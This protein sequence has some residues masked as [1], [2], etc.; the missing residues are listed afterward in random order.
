[1]RDDHHGH[2]FRRE[3]LH[4]VQ[5]LADDLGVQGRGRLVKEHDLGLHAQCPCNGDTL[6]LSAGQARCIGV[7]KVLEPYRRQ[8]AYGRLLR[9]RPRDPADRHGRQGTVIQDISVVEEIE[10][11]EHHADFLPQGV[12]V[13]AQVHEVLPVKPDAAG[14]GLLQQVDAAQQRRFSR[15]GGADDA[16]HLAAVYL[17]ID[18]FEH[19][20]VA[21][22]LFQ[23]FDAQHGLLHNAASLV[24]VSAHH[25][26]SLSSGCRAPACPASFPAS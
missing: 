8:M 10:A 15:A 1:M 6:L 16:H 18:A 20:Q 11:L 9:L 7:D 4:H 3:R 23:A 2:P 25:G 12:Q 14:I 22:G 26:L 19:L 17:Q 13:H 21:E 24:I 5:H